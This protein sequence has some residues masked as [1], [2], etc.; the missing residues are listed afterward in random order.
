MGDEGSRLNNR[1]YI[2]RAIE[3]L[4]EIE[5]PVPLEIEPIVSESD[6]GIEV[7]WPIIRAKDARPFPGPD[8]HAAVIMDHKA[9]EIVAVLG[10]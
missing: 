10:G 7:T 1:V 9:E 8:I 3:A 4:R 6:E 2:N 5:Y